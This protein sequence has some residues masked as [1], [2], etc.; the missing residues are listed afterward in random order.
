[1]VFGP[2]CQRD[3]AKI[4]STNL[5]HQRCIQRERLL[6]EK[7]HAFGEQRER[8]RQMQMSR[9][10]DHRCIVAPRYQSFIKR[11][12]TGSSVALSHRHEQGWIR[13]AGRDGGAASLLEAAQMPLADA[14]AADDQK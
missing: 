4:G 12:K 11:G 7:M 5:R 6:D 8:H 2:W 14:A 10:A 9:R 1:M 13:I 3:R